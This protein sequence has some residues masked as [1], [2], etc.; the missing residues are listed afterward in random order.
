[1]PTP[2]IQDTTATPAGDPSPTIAAFESA[3]VEAAASRLQ[4]LHGLPDAEDDPVVAAQ[5]RTLQQTLAEIEVARQRLASGSYGD[6][7]GCGRPIPAAR[8]ELRPWAATCVDCA[9]R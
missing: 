8:L 7:A 6:C 4:Q 9:G 1:M 3:L 2:S 5:R